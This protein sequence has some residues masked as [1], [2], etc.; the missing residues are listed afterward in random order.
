VNTTE[1][2]RPV[3][4]PR[5]ADEPPRRRRRTP[6]TALIVAL[7]TTLNALGW[8]LVVAPYHVPD[9]ASHVY[10]AQY[11]GETGKLPAI[12]PGFRWYSEDIN[13]MLGDGGLYY[14]IGQPENRPPWD[15]SIER[16]LR[17]DQAADLE[18]KGI[19]DAS[20]ASNNPPVYYLPQAALYRVAH[21]LGP[22]NR[23]T[24][25]RALSA[26]MAGLTALCI[27]AF[28][29]ELLPGS[30]LAWTVGALAAGLQPMF[31][32]ISSGVN[33]DAGLYLVSAALMLA[34]ARLLRRGLT[35]GRA[36][37][38]GVLLGAGVLVKTQAIA[39]APAV[40]LALLVAARRA[41]TGRLRGVGA[42]ILAGA[43]PLALYGVLG[44]TIWNR[45]LLDRAGDLNL[46]AGTARPGSL[47]E[48][49][50]FMWQEYLPRLPFMSDLLP[51]VQ[52]YRVWFQGMI[53]DFGWLDYRF[54][55][56]V[57]PL[58]LGVVLLL[59]VAALR[60][61]WARRAGLRGRL[62]EVAVFALAAAGLMGAVALISYRWYLLGAPFE[63][64]RYL[65]PL[66]PFFALL[67]ALAVRGLG[68]FAPVAG[69]VI[70]TLVLGLSVYG[71]LLTIARYYG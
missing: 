23:L 22:M 19:G 20:S 40:G 11:F 26:L 14:V 4:A 13:A 30:P 42:G 58:A 61:L 43:A 62:A 12:R 54:P 46:G 45:P 48:Q 5:P 1:Q 39:F 68:R 9:E 50:S 67:P 59:A 25:M 32:F 60:G 6:R 17:V 53:G 33:N 38:V 31:A 64:A 71:Q 41:H 24:L 36:A 56:W 15:S 28:L 3:V 49:I 70:V 52:A 10:Y 66:L 35:P 37:T 2:H 69:V 16:R 8:G 44:A 21:G 29:R 34:L 47:T 57:Y 27:F 65:L 7:L 18:R 63:Q 51:G 55:D